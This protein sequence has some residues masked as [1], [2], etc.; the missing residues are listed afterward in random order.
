MTLWR[1]VFKS[2]KHHLLSTLITAG[3]IALATGLWIAV[4][5]TQ[6]QA[7]STFASVN[8]GFDAV[9]GA[10][11]SQLQLVLNA[12]FHLEASPGNL[13]AKDLEDIRKDER[14]QLAVPIAVGDNYL[15]YRL[16]GTSL[17]MFEKAEQSPG[18][19]LHPQPGGRLFDPSRR[20]ALVGSF[21]AQ[22]MG[23]RLGD[24]FKPYHGLNF[25]SERAT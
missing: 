3:S 2:L 13:P 23:L 9:L 1:I 16:V 7:Q 20:E 15:G 21:A 10:R 24:S 17:E 12:I 19:R 8:A 18:H 11:G 22:R 4:W 25:Q 6:S 14:V 5:V